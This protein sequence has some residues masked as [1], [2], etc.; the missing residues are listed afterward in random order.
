MNSNNRLVSIYYSSVEHIT[1]DSVPC[2][3]FIF[4]YLLKIFRILFSNSDDCLSNSV[5]GKRFKRFPTLRTSLSLSECS[6]LI[7]H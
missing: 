1:V 6:S 7:Y 3:P 2:V 5:F 4:I